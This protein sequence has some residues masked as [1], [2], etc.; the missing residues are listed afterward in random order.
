MWEVNSRSS[1]RSIFGLLLFDLNLGSTPS[2]AQV[3]STSHLS[4]CG[5]SNP[6]PYPYVGLPF[7]L[8]LGST[9]GLG[10][11]VFHL[12]LLWWGV[13]SIS[14]SSP[15]SVSPQ[16]IEGPLQIQIQLWIHVCHVPFEL[17][18]G[19]RRGTHSGSSSSP[20]SV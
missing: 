9:P 10:P 3:P 20:I 4:S 12:S 16:L 18:L 19:G 2:P 7:E 17:N 6:A 13:Y 11:S 1:S 8:N 14:G 15:T 5:G